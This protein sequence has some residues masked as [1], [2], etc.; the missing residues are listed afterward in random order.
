MAKKQSRRGTPKLRRSSRRAALSAEP[1][2]LTIEKLERL[3]RRPRRVVDPA[4]AETQA[5]AKE[6]LFQE[7][8]DAEIF[9]TIAVLSEQEK[10]R[11]GR[12][13]EPRSPAADPAGRPRL[14]R[15]P[16]LTDEEFLMHRPDRPLSDGALALHLKGKLGRPVSPDQARR[17]R[18]R[19]GIPA[20]PRN[21]PRSAK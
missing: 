7:L 8:H 3:L 21:S 9:R 19:L 11:R 15:P 12:R 2:Y 1:R 6:A 5:R 16:E 18:V 20:T 14:G 4:E 10:G 17:T 13:A